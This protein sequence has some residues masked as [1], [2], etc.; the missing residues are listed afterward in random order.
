[1]RILTAAEMR[2]ADRLTTERYGVPS[3]TLMENAGGGVAEYVRERYTNFAAREI[4]VLC[5]KGNNGGDGLVAARHLL[6]NGARPLVYLFADPRDMSGDAAAN[7]RRWKQAGGKVVLAKDS[8]A[9]DGA[10]WDA[11][12]G[13]IVIDALLGT[14]VRGPVEGA[15]ERLIERVNTQAPRG[16]VV[17]VDVPSGLH[18]DS[19]EAGGAAILADAT[20]TFTAPKAGFFLGAGPRHAGRLVVCAIG[21]PTELIDE[22]GKGRLRWSEPREFLRFAQPRRLGGHKGDYGHALIVAG[23]VGK[24]GAAVLASWA[25]LRAGAGLVTVAT[26]EPALPVVAAHIPEAMTEPL[27]ATRAGTVSERCLEGDVLPRLLAGKRALAIGPGLSTNSETQNFMRGVVASQGAIPVILDADGL[28]A[29][30]GRAAE[31]KRSGRF[32]AVTPHPGEMARL[33]GCSNEEIQRRRVDL[34][35]QAAAEWDAHVVLKGYQTIVAAPDGAAYINSTGNPGMAS[36]GT[37][38]A[39]T[40]LLAGLTAQYGTENWG[41]LLAFGV[42]LHGLAGDIAWSEAGQA[43]LM[44]S[45]L[46]RSIPRAYRRFY[47]ECG[48][49]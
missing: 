24:T 19:G 29:Y 30:A 22:V 36:G 47:S 20:V 34:A 33:L 3:R 10:G 39:L 27:A 38:D 13:P 49:D 4:L 44:A 15:L 28:N 43:P 45:D 42:F 26:P 18:A 23:S 8:S 5:G 12:G 16:S 35:L 14:G 40:G 21:S 48:C 11:R 32:L 25:A 37:G 41:G 6:K 7:L 1:M 17:A 2:E 9:L 46:I 31:L